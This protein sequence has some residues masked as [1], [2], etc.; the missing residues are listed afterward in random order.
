M[1]E[2]DQESLEHIVLIWII[3]YGNGEVELGRMVI[4]KRQYL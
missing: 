4:E 3:C 1:E 2:K